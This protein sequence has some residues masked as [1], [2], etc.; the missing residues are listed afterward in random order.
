MKI[1]SGSRFALH[2]F[3]EGCVS[4]PVKKK[5]LEEFH[6]FLGIADAAE[7]QT[8]LPEVAEC[9]GISSQLAES[10]RKL[11]MQKLGRDAVMICV[12]PKY[13]KKMEKDFELPTD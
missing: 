12:L 6:N 8:N 7:R 1:S 3:A 10:F 5:Q 13:Q 4:F 2:K 9:F 11:V